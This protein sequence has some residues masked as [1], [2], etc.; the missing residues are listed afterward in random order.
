MRSWIL[1]VFSAITL[2]VGFQLAH[3]ADDATLTALL[4]TFREEFVPLTPGKEKFPASFVRGDTRGAESEA[5]TQEITLTESFA[6]A[7]YEMPQNLY[8]AVMGKNPGRWKGPRNSVEMMSWRDARDCCRKL[9]TLLQER[10]LIDADQEIRLP[11]ET[12]WEY[13]CRAGTKSRYS[14]G[15]D[16][17]RSDDPPGKNTILDEYGWYTGNAA[18]ND[19]PVGALKPNA[20]GL[21]DMH[22]Y[23]WE[24]TADTWTPNYDGVSGKAR[25]PEDETTPVVLRSGSWK[26]R[27]DRLTSAARQRFPQ[28]GADDAV[29]F[30]CVLAKKR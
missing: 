12:E 20:W 4:K 22:G 17:R 19:P 24:F 8:E 6:I 23:L 10:K 29:G 14:F 2:G 30:R 7:K 16:I 28:T 1:F 3:A 5:P 11:T 26:D 18:G 13:A 25:P 27:A 9:T 21:Y 15:D